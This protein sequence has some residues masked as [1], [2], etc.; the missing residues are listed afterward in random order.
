M[1]MFF[2]FIVIIKSNFLNKKTEQDLKDSIFLFTQ[3]EVNVYQMSTRKTFFQRSLYS[4][5]L[6]IQLTEIKTAKGV[7]LCCIFF[8]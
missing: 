5:F 6:N 4:F 7:T 1:D 2:L 8:N 3:H